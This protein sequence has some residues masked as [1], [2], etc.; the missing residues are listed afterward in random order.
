M[1]FGD[2]FPIG[3]IVGSEE[4]HLVGLLILTVYLIFPVEQAAFGMSAIT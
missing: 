4:K 3:V 1:V 2:V